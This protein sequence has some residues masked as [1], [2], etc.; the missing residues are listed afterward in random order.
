MDLLS[1]TG[2]ILAAGDRR[3]HEQ[4]LKHLDWQGGGSYEQSEEKIDV[5]FQ[6]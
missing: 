4:A 3:T 5:T 1:A 2:E 6:S